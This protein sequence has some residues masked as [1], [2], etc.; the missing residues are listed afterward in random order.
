MTEVHAS[1]P[2]NTLYRL[3]RVEAPGEWEAPGGVRPM[4]RLFVVTATYRDPRWVCE[5]DA[6]TSSAKMCGQLSYGTRNSFIDGLN[7]LVELSI[8]TLHDEWSRDVTWTDRGGVSY[9]MQEE[10]AYVCGRAVRKTGCTPGIRDANHDGKSLDE[11]MREANEYIRARRE[12]RTHPN[13]AGTGASLLPEEY[14]YL[15]REEVLA[16]RLY[17]GPGFQPINEFLR[18]LSTLSGHPTV[19]RDF[20]QHPRLSLA[21]TVSHLI[22]A[23]RKLAAIATEEDAA[24]PLWRGVRGTLSPDF[25]SPDDQKMLVA[26]DMAFMS[27]S[28]EEET[29]KR[30]MQAGTSNVLWALHPTLEDDTGYHYGADVSILSQFEAEK[31]ILFPPPTMLVVTVNAP[32]NEQTVASSHPGQQAAARFMEID[33]VP[34]FV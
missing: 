31:E 32:P 23:I 3:I 25:W 21:A 7:D 8:F 19:R 11:L 34:T 29:P 4:Q 28:R 30:Y 10:Y 27:T 33:C 15:T 6:H 17:T 22:D 24:R 2:P 16:V 26:V 1:Y 14:A 9:T 20:L 5:R 13:P 18:S 12:Q